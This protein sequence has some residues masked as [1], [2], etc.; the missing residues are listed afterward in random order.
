MSF[1]KYPFSKQSR[2]D[3]TNLQELKEKELSR[4]VV[5]LQVSNEK[6]T[7]PNDKCRFSSREE[8]SNKKQNRKIRKKLYW[9]REQN[10]PL[11]SEIKK[12]NYTSTV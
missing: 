12:V 9:G 6:K 3:P 4:V 5:K 10:E 7:N 11:K 1:I 2:S 8:N